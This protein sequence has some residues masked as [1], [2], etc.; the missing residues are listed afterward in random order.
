MKNK[1][2]LVMVLGASLVSV[3][4]ASCGSTLT[5]PLND[6]IKRYDVRLQVKGSPKTLE[7]EERGNTKCD[8]HPGNPKEKFGC[9][10]VAQGDQAVITFD[11]KTGS[12]HMDE[13][14]ICKGATKETQD[15]NLSEAERQE[16]AVMELGGVSRYHPS[17]SGVI[18]FGQIPRRVMDFKLID[19]NTIA[20]DYFYS[21]KACN[22]GNTEC[23]ETDPPI[24]NGGK[25]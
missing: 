11:L 14:K 15:C 13:M 7:I 21:L 2:G 19:L 10:N 3:M 8:N 20:G 25:Q 23:V 18:D 6:N 17:S 1:L 24:R 9:I 4:L 5:H 22:N 12:W 16:F